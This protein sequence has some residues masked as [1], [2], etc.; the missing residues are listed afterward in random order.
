MFF[1]AREAVLAPLRKRTHQQTAA[2]LAQ[3][4]GGDDQARPRRRERRA[5]DD[6]GATVCLGLHR[7]WAV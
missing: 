6:A 2:S 3:M 5:R 4:T 7:F 1:R